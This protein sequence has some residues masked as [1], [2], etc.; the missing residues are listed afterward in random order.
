M[1]RGYLR[2]ASWELAQRRRACSEKYDTATRSA[3]AI[4]FKT[5]SE[6]L[7]CIEGS[8]LSLTSKRTPRKP[9]RIGTL[10]TKPAKRVDS[11][12]FICRWVFVVGV[13][14]RLASPEVFRALPRLRPAHI[15]SQAD[16]NGLITCRHFTCGVIFVA[17]VRIKYVNDRSGGGLSPRWCT[18]VSPSDSCILS[19]E[20]ACILLVDCTRH[21]LFLSLLPSS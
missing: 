1:G 9:K 18:A 17:I 15:R 4:F 19:S 21:L 13:V 8:S 6:K 5:N 2:P 7:T 10:T 16:D 11:F 20:R 12:A 14:R 3:P